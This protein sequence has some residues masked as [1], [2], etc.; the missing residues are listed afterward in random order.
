MIFYFFSIF[1]CFIFP[2]FCFLPLFG[3]AELPSTKL[4]TLLLDHKDTKLTWY[5]DWPRKEVL[6]NVEHAFDLDGDDIQWFSFG[7]SKRGELEASDLCFFVQN[8][9]DDEDKGVAIVRTSH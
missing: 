8:S 5:I 9:M 3:N 4:H 1:R 6:F 2:Y 7:F